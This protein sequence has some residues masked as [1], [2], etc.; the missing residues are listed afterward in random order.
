MSTKPV[1]GRDGNK[2]ICATMEL[3]V[4]GGVIAIVGKIWFENVSVLIHIL[5]RKCQVL[6]SDSKNYEYKI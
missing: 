2:K 3:S 1:F 5:F 4:G 6:M